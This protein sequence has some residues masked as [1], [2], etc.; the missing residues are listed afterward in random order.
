MLRD[1]RATAAR[2]R[3]APIGAGG[4]EQMTGGRRLET[5]MGRRARLPISA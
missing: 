1:P 5:L 4:G 2:L 3:A